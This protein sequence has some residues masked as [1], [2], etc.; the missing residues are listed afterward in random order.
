[1]KTPVAIAVAC[2]AM[3]CA[4]AGPMAAASAQD[5]PNRP[6]RV[7]V[8][9]GAGSAFDILARALGEEFKARTG[10]PFI[11]D[12][13]PGGNQIVAAN[14]L[15]GAE[16]DGYT[17]ALFTQSGITLNPLLRHD[18][19]YDPVKD[20]APVAIAALTQQVFVATPMADVG[21]FTDLVK[22]S[23]AHKDTLNFA[24]L[25]PDSDGDLILRWVRAKMSGNWAHIP[26]RGSPPIVAALKGGEVQMTLLTYGSLK[27]LIDTGAVKPL[28]TRGAA[29]RSPLLPNVPTYDEAGLPP[30]DVKAWAGVFARAGTPPAVVARLHREI[31]AIIDNASFRTRFMDQP[32]LVPVAVTLDDIG[33]F[34]AKDREAWGRLVKETNNQP[35]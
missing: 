29:E 11:V 2:G 5:F 26:Y 8:P 3:L 14:A 34:L 22:Y 9:L 15:K 6:V 31:T 20:F 24:T 18:L 1:M 19:S 35:K 27:A 28:F 12:N 7:L 17:I 4:L 13:R 32:G 10:Q 21:T 25:G 23:Q 16:P 33:S 30:L